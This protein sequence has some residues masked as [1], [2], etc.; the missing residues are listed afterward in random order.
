MNCSDRGD[1]IAETYT[2]EYIEDGNLLAGADQAGF[3]TYYTRLLQ[4]GGLK[5]GFSWGVF[6]LCGG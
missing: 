2:V 6:C 3:L 1:F 4:E 5:D